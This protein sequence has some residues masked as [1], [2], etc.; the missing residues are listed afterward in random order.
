MLKL[1]NLCV[2]FIFLGFL[3]QTFAQEDSKVLV[4]KNKKEID[5][6]QKLLP[7]QQQNVQND[8]LKKSKRTFLGK[9]SKKK[10][11]K[12]RYTDYKI[13]SHYNDTTLIDTTLTIQ[14]EYKM[15]VFRKDL[16]GYL[17]F[18]NEGQ[19]MNMLTYDFDKTKIIPDMGFTAKHVGYKKVEDIR[20]YNVPIPSAEFYYKMGLEQGDVVDAFFTTNFARY[21]NISFAYT[22]LRSLGSYRGSLSSFSNFRYTTSY[23]TPNKRYYFRLHFAS[24]DILN[25]Q[26]GGLTEKS[27]E[28]FVNN[29]EDFKDDRGRMDI[30]LPKDTRDTLQGTR[31]YICQELKLFNPEKYKKNNITVGHSFMYEK[32]SFNFFAPKHEHFGKYFKQTSD[33]I[34][35][36][37]TVE[38]KLYVLLKSPHL[39][40]NLRIGTNYT[41]LYQGYRNI[42]FQNNQIT[43]RL[44]KYNLFGVNAL[45]DVTLGKINLRTHSK[46]NLTRE[47]KGY[48]LSNQITYNFAK[49]WELFG[50]ISLRSKAP[51]FT[52]RFFQSNYLDYN[53]NHQFENTTIQNFKIALRS[54]WFI[55][56][57]SANRIQNYMYFFKILKPFQ[58]DE[59]EENNRQLPKN[60]IALQRKQYKENIDYFKIKLQH[61]LKVW[62]FALNNTILYQKTLN[63]PNILN[64]PKLVARSTFYF[65]ELLFKQRSLFL[66]T[67]FT[68]NYFSR[69]YANDYNPVVGDFVVQNRKMIGHHPI[70]EFFAN[71]RV[72]Q[73]RL[74]FKIENVLGIWSEKN[75]FSAPNYPSR[76][77]TINFGFVWNFKH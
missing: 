70:L 53:W 47:L 39:L 51:D 56:T 34:T 43:P 74:F 4:K 16:F 9:K 37:K 5:S 17:P 52:Y 2:L 24:Q 29:H 54:K 33:D 10:K 7:Q 22:G 77:F 11:Q 61:E 20:Y 13:I 6:L 28:N 40:G 1:Q 55:L 38:N 14:K 45:W 18:H 71:G 35:S 27:V 44:I 58:K 21:F 31:Y 57:A 32:K 49:D 76:D 30:F 62:K 60:T 46:I 48:L 26:S 12:A 73:T 19:V 75:Y 64:V 50:K 67:G 66:Q 65:S 36:F 42:I 3:E 63:N 72:R 15:N 25:Q 41:Y 8:S 59:S 23:N 69:Y 68:L